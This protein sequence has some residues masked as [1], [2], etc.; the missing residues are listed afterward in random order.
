MIDHAAN[1]SAEPAFRTVH[2]YYIAKIIASANNCAFRYTGLCTMY[3]VVAS[4]VAIISVVVNV[5]A[6][7]MVAKYF[8][9]KSMMT[10][11]VS[12][13]VLLLLL[14]LLSWLLHCCWDCAKRRLPTLCCHYNRYNDHYI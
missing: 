6:I 4:V 9:M 13:V 3:L 1:V 12:V 11:V 10:R 14:M 2:V 5:V 7:V 8:Q